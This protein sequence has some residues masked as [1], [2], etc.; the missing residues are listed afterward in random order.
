M[1]QFAYRGASGIPRIAL[2]PVAATQTLYKG[3]PVVRASGVL[4][5]MAGG[6][7]AGTVV[8]VMNQDSVLADAGTLVEVILA[9]ADT[10]FKADFL[11]SGTKKSFVA[12]DLATAFD[13]GATTNY[14][15]IDPDDTTGG[16]WVPVKT[17]TEAEGQVY[18]KCAHAQRD[19]LAG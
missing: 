3:D 7:S 11:T 1:F 13:V 19:P 15:Q 2:I 16:S 4:N 10:V 14:N 18:V 9:D 12:A 5:V 17:A 8:G 6:A